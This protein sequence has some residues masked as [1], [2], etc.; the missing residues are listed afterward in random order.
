MLVQLLVG[1]L[2]YLT[3]TRLDIAFVINRVGDT[4]DTSELSFYVWFYCFSWLQ[5]YILFHC[6]LLVPLTAS[7]PAMQPHCRRET[8]VFV[9]SLV[10]QCGAFAL[11]LA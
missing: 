3:F 11:G 9:A 1:L 4:S 5:S 7:S 8:G 6:D 2:Q 10:S